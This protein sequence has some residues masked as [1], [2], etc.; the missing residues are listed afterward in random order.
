MLSIAID[1]NRCATMNQVKWDI[2][3][4]ANRDVGAVIADEG[5]YRRALRSDA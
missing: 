1:G 3:V 2:K 4:S 5:G